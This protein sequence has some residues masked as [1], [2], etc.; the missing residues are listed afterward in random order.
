MR[1][2]I[3]AIGSQG[4]VRPNVA[5]GLGLK[6]EGHRVRVVTLGGFDELVRGHGLEHLAI[7]GSP[8]DIANTVAGRDWIAHRATTLGFLRGF[9][10]VARTLIQEGIASYWSACGDVDALIVNSLGL[11]VGVHVAERLRVPLIRTHTSPFTPTRYDYN[12]RRDLMTAVQ[13]DLTTWMGAAFR[14]AMWSMLRSTTNASRRNILQLPPLPLQ[15]PFSEMDRHRLPVLDAYSPAV[16]TRPPDWGDWIHVTGYWFLHDDA[17]W[18]PPPSLI[19]FLKAGRPPVFVGFGSTPFPNPDTATRLVVNALTSAGQR[20]IVVTGGS[21][22][23][24]GRL[25]DH[26]LSVDAVP[27]SWLFP[28]V[29][30]AVHHGGAGVTA[31]ALR[32]GLPCVVV[33]VFADQPFWGG[34]VFDLG[35]GP[36]PIPAKQLT[37]DGLAGAIRQTSRPEIRARAAELGVQ[38]RAENGVAR[39]IEAIHDHLGLT[40]RERAAAHTQSRAD[41]AARAPL[42]CGSV[43]EDTG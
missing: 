10:A 13:G 33:P 37:A 4:D 22:L 19:D 7:G 18:F 39:A 41:H 34:R 15:E 26:I 42:F 9:V 32:A 5:L 20:G 24:A 43:H 27:H 38:I 12:G 36:R 40:R 6:K 30:A 25:T 31:A 21:G 28:Q 29:S 16:V 35:A 11:G 2:D 3:L 8:R 14:F 23:A 1:I 17:G